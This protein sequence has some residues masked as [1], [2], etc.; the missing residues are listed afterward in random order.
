M[1]YLLLP[2]GL[3]L[4]CILTIFLEP[5][6]P[7][8]SVKLGCYQDNRYQM[9][10]TGYVK[11]PDEKHFIQ[12]GNGVILLHSYESMLDRTTKKVQCNP[13]WVVK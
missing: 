1:K 8:T 11:K 13:D 6:I 9:F 7:Q 2:I 4:G 3:F 5:Y 12:M 10:V